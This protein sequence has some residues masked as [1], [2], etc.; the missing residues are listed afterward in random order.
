MLDRR[1]IEESLLETVERT[2]AVYTA[3]SKNFRAV[4]KEIPT[5]LP[6]P[7]G[8]NSIEIAGRR[9]QAALTAYRQALAVF[10]RYIL[11]G[12]LPDDYSA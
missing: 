12:V 7:D 4:V 2:R 3:A 6:Q 11:D 9:E 5:G 1:Q 10:N 8:V